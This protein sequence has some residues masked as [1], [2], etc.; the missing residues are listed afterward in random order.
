M[1]WKP[2]Q[3]AKGVTCRGCGRHIPLFK[4]P[5]GDTAI[6][7]PDKILITCGFPTCRREHEYTKSDLQSFIVRVAS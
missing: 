1:E 5:P 2:G 4:I 3:R 7:P 6:E